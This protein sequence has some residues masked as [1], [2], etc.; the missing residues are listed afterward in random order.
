[1]R[2]DLE[3]LAETYLNYSPKPITDLIGKK[4]KNQRTMRSVALEE[5]KEY[6]VEDANITYQLKEFFDKEL[7]ETQT[8]KLYEEIKTPLLKVLAE[9]ELEGIHV[10]REF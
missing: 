1:M 4:G 8:K 6:A 2:S 10:N 9:M 3:V 7:E 5:Q